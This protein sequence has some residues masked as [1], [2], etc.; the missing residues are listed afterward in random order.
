MAQRSRGASND[1][2]GRQN[3]RTAGIKPNAERD[4]RHREASEQKAK[5]PFARRKRVTLAVCVQA[6]RAGGGADGGAHFMFCLYLCNSCYMCASVNV[7]VCEL[8]CPTH[9]TVFQ[10]HALV[11]SCQTFRI[12][13]RRPPG[14]KQR[15]NKLP[16]N[17]RQSPS[18]CLPASSSSCHRRVDVIIKNHMTFNCY[19]RQ[20]QQRS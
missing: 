3:R 9:S 1:G 11:R 5:N 13:L 17:I 14:A 12:I 4:Q 7:C 2:N 19:Q 18:L 16:D 10:P 6:R 20:Q 8:L 15:Q